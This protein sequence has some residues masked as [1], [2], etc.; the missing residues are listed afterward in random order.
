LV[1]ETERLGVADGGWGWG[2]CFLD[3]DN[4]S[5]LDIVQ[6]NGW[7]EPYLGHRVWQTPTA[8]AFVMKESGT[9]AEEAQTLGLAEAVASR[10]VVCADFDQDGDT[11]ILELTDAA[12]NSARLWE[13]RTAAAGRHS[14]RIRLE[15]LP[16]NTRSAGARIFVRIGDVT[17]MREI[18]IGSN[19][20][21]QN[22]VVQ[23]FG[24][25]SSRF[26]DELLVEWPPLTGHDGPEQLATLVRG[27]IAASE[28]R[29]TL[30]LRHPQLPPL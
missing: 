8:R 20:A 14:L 3:L 1:D 16:P 10:G 15:G 24:L 23:I 28:P 22:P 9:Y 27:P 2:A 12:P 21:T 11:D 13:N 17:Q 6:T 26:V 7:S 19:Y 4:D 29:Q 5:D 18:T 25:D 30:F